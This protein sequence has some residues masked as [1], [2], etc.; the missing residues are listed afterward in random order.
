MALAAWRFFVSA[1]LL[2][3]RVGDPAACGGR[4][5]TLGLGSSRVA[6]ALVA[7]GRLRKLLAGGCAQSG[8]V[9]ELS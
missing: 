2:G 9:T 7:L 8:E 3:F 4:L 5:Q 6:T 1:M